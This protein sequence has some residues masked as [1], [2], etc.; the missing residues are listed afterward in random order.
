LTDL[1]SSSSRRSKIRK[2]SI[3]TRCRFMISPANLLS[4][5]TRSIW[6]V[7]IDTLLLRV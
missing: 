4:E 1:F 7:H 2:F 6:Y 5:I 3:I